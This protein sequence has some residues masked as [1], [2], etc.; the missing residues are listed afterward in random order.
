[1]SSVIP[2]MQV[3]VP[4]LQLLIPKLIEVWRN[5][6]PEVPLEEWLAALGRDRSMAQIYAEAEARRQNAYGT[7][8]A[9]VG[10]V[11]PVAK[12]TAIEIL[13][14]AMTDVIP[15]WFTPVEKLETQ[16]LRLHILHHG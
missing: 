7:A 15:E 1:M 12:A 13:D 8:V 14:A 9:E 5:T 4:A 11:K 3:A 2:I 16:K 10:A 6:S